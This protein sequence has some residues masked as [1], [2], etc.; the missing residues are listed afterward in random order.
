MNVSQKAI[1]IGSAIG[2]II[3]IVLVFSTMYL[4]DYRTL[5]INNPDKI[6]ILL[7]YNANNK[8]EFIMRGPNWETKQEV[9]RWKYD[10][11]YL[12]LYS[13][14]Y[15]I[16]RSQWQVKTKSGTMQNRS[17]VAGTPITY[18][19]TNKDLLKIIKISNYQ[20]KHTLTELQL[21]TKLISVENFPEKYYV[22]FEPADS[23]EYELV[24]KIMDI[25]ITA[26]QK[27]GTYTTICSMSFG[28]N[29][30][31][32]WCRSFDKFSYAYLSKTYNALYVH[33]KVAKGTQ[34]LDVSLTDPAS[35]TD[36]AYRQNKGIY[37]DVT[38]S[39]I[40][41]AGQNVRFKWG[42]DTENVLVPYKFAEMP[43][44]FEH[45]FPY[46]ID[47]C[48]REIEFKTSY[49]ASTW[50]S[51]DYNLYS[52]NYRHE[53]RSEKCAEP[54]DKD[55]C[56]LEIEKEFVFQCCD[57]LEDNICDYTAAVED[58]T[59]TTI[60]RSHFVPITDLDSCPLE[61]KQHYHFQHR[62]EIPVNST[63]VFD[64][65]AVFK[66]PVLGEFRFLIPAPSW[67]S[68]S[69]ND[70]NSGNA[71]DFNWTKVTW[72]G[73]I[74]PVGDDRLHNDLNQA[75]Y[76]QNLI[77]Y[78]KFNDVNSTGN[79]IRD[80]TNRGND[81]QLISG[82]A[83]NVWGMW[84]TNAL[85][86]VD[87]VDDYVERYNPNFGT[88]DGNLNYPLT[89]VAW[90]KVPVEVYPPL[91][92]GF[93]WVGFGPSTNQ[94]FG[95]GIGNGTRGSAFLNAR[96]TSDRI[97]NGNIDVND[98]SWHHIVGVFSSSTLRQLYVDGNYDVQDV[99]AAVIPPINKFCMGRWCDF[100]PGF[101]FIGQIDEVKLYNR[102]LSAAEIQADY[103]SWMKSNYF[104]PV[105]DA[106]ANV[107]WDAMDWNA[108]VDVN[109]NV[110]VDYR[111][112]STADCSSAGAWQ[113]NLRGSPPGTWYSDIYADNNRYFQYRVNFDTNKQ[114]WNPVRTGNADKGMFGHFSN[115]VV[116]YSTIGG[117]TTCDCPTS[118]NWEIND[119]SI[120]TLSTTCNL[121]A[122]SLHISNG[123]LTITTTG[124]LSIPIGYKIIIEK[125]NSKLVVEKG[126]K[127]II[128]K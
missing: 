22:T 66:L 87:G 121:S 71:W 21:F 95:M 91:V 84:D 29:V 65:N 123:S 50:F 25:N 47:P 33:F 72:D 61:P 57:R 15:I 34:F 96:N 17:Y 89:I 75:F 1:T 108:L 63:I 90:V 110:T 18:D 46:A 24:W 120:C 12:T 14:Q 93:F 103:N 127:V 105:K 118:G 5:L 74:M 55:C 92:G 37:I 116:T 68:T 102:A 83:I 58:G 80:D 81:G 122:G 28:N 6:A 11:D 52:P 23:K 4:A 79:G 54:F 19:S 2:G 78:W 114:Q 86:L 70:Y 53:A 48:K 88:S 40:R 117:V 38:A 126:G 62:A 13:N 56:F 3:L 73:N 64:V 85:S 49:P 67:T 41:V 125:T 69:A 101:N 32:N 35:F 112:C 36:L 20:N 8:L 111:G 51:L 60:P 97:K 82:A 26:G 45:N 98:G 104:S 106:G 27:Q 113:T 109:N 39:N 76:D 77:G 9:T 124:V 42:Y 94:Y 128:N 115:V 59:F 44:W 30:E 7:D 107:N 119:A 16:A 43:F 99:T 100:S 31:V 10:Q